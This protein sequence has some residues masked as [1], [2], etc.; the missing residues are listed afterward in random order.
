MTLCAMNVETGGEGV[1]CRCAGWVAQSLWHQRGG[2][3]NRQ[4][5]PAVAGELVRATLWGHGKHSPHRP[6]HEIPRADVRTVEVFDG[7]IRVQSDYQVVA[8][9]SAAHV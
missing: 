9:D 1:C 3:P 8:I 2:V 4:L 6:P 5:D 7:S